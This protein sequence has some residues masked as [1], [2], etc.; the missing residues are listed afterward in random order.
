[1]KVLVIGPH[2]TRA[3]GGMS[4]VIQEIHKSELLNRA[5]EID[6]F[7]S[8]IDGS[9]AVRVLYSAYRYLCFLLCWRKY[10][11]FHIH[12]A[13]RGSVLRK[14][15]YLRKIKQA[16][17]RAIVHIHAA[18][19]P[20]FYDSLGRQGKQVVNGF[21]CRAD[22][23]LA[24]SDSQ[25]RELVSRVPMNACHIL[26]N[27]VDPARFQGAVTDVWAHRNSFLML[28]RLGARKG[29]Y[30]LIAAVEIAVKQNP[31]IRI[32]LAGDGEVEQI[33]AIV[34][35]KGLEGHIVV[36]GWVD[37]TR[38]LEYLQEAATVVLPSYHEGLPLSILEGMAAGKA[39]IATNVGAVP[40][41]IAAE[42]GIL[43]DPGDV[44]ALAEALLCCSRNGSLLEDMSLKNREKVEHLFGLGRMHGL[45][46]GY[47]REAGRQEGETRW[48]RGNRLSA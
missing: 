35:R 47:Y 2:E 5:F 40:E 24:L 20:A 13:E 46:A 8:Y 31:D 41:V 12:V 36:P 1:M 33:R 16:G 21:F 30:D 17:K 34:A 22:H 45:L 23:V 18:E 29:V 32:C 38:K 4:A 44:P 39:I 37:D 43:L 42:N 15:L 11:L 48:S 3:R 19:F 9:L 10:D 27:G 6:I 7:P 26:H 14:N 28:G 25:R